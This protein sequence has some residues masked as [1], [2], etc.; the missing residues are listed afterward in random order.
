M[1]DY[2]GDIIS[3]FR[4]LD[5]VIRYLREYQRELAQKNYHD[6]VLSASAYQLQH[7]YTGLEKI[8]EKSLASKNIKVEKSASYHKRLLKTY[9]ENFHLAENEIVFVADL[10]AF[11][12]F[13]R[14]AYGSELDATLIRQKVTLA[15]TVWDGIK[16]KISVQMQLDR[17]SAE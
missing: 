10:L 2:R 8:I 12:H 11:R 15:L 17:W 13:T 5:N 3:D 7:L 1:K 14:S 16:E 6:S 4:R 9:V